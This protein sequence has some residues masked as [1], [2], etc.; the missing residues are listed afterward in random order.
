LN[1]FNLLRTF[2][3]KHTNQPKRLISKLSITSLVSLYHP[4][5]QVYN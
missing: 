2:G 3:L 4:S 5:I 1:I